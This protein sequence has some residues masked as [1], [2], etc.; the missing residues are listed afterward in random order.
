MLL[1]AE[2]FRHFFFKEDSAIFIK[3]Y[4][5][6]SINDTTW[7]LEGIHV[8]LKSLATVIMEARLALDFPLWTNA[9]TVQLLKHLAILRLMFRAKWK[10]QY[11]N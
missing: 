4:F 5:T 2:D 7:A 11:T 6:R 9:Q 8:S 10:S 3:P 1:G